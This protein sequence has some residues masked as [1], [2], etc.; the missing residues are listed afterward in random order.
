MEDAISSLEKRMR[1]WSLGGTSTD[2]ESFPTAAWG[3]S[4]LTS[5][6]LLMWALSQHAGKMVYKIPLEG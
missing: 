2:P 4:D 1:A 5:V 3:V 6:L